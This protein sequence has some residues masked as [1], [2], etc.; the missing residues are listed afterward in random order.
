ML[1]VSCRPH[2]VTAVRLSAAPRKLAPSKACTAKSR[3]RQKHAPPNVA[4]L[5]ALSLHYDVR[6]PSIDAL[7]TA[8]SLDYGL[9]RRRLQR[10]AWFDASPENERAYAHPPQAL[11]GFLQDTMFCRR[12][13]PKR[14]ETFCNLVHP[15][16]NPTQPA[17]YVCAGRVWSGG[18]GMD[19]RK[20]VWQGEEILQDSL[21][22]I[23]ASIL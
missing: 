6:P 20:R 10:C 9:V 22:A 17:L 19:G 7:S 1:Q 16:S 18:P 14:C 23:P 5:M 11:A 13:S 21:Y 3:H 8:L 12:E 4:P 2:P 15:T